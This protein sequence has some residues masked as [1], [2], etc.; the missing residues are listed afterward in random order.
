[1]TLADHTSPPITTPAVVTGSVHN[2]P[3]KSDPGKILI[4]VDSNLI[5][6][7]R[8]ITFVGFGLITL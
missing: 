7:R 1:M 8:L 2:I 4:S 5:S 6:G 3:P